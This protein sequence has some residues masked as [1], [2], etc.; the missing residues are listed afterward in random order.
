MVIH[1]IRT[2]GIN[3]IIDVYSEFIV[4]KRN[5][6]PMHIVRLLAQFH[7]DDDD[8]DACCEQQQLERDWDRV[9]DLLPSTQ[10]LVISSIKQYQA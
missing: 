7:N 9:S 8:R 3:V 10:M 5:L 1:S 6:L 4:L 2:C